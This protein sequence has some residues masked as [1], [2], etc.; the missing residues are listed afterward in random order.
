MIGYEN[1]TVVKYVLPFPH[2]KQ[3]FYEKMKL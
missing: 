3:S 1:T 2:E